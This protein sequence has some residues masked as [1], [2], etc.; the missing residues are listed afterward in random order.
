MFAENRVNKSQ[1]QA[2]KEEIK[3]PSLQN[4]PDN[5]LSPPKVIEENLQALELSGQKDSSKGNN[6]QQELIFINS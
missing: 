1:P 2:N 3:K 4:E 5:A 6:V